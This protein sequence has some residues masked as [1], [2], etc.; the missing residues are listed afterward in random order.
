MKSYS[1]GN[2][3]KNKQIYNLVGFFSFIFFCI[4]C[5][6]FLAL[7]FLVYQSCS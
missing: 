7:I 3:K 2:E 1:G 5:L 6:G 4:L